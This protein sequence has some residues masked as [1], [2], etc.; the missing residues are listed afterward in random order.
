M[1]ADEVLIIGAGPFGLSISAH[2]RAAGIAHRIVGR[3][4][5]TWKAHMPAGMM[6]R[7]EPYGSDMAAPQPRAR[8]CAPIASNHGLDYVRPAG[9]ADASSGSWT[10]PTGTR[11]S[12]CRTSAT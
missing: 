7:S 4:M 2:L 10:T 1:P 6:L 12:W 3:P 9:P 8:T 11:A 5:D